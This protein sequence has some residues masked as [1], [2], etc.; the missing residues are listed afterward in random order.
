MYINGNG[1][2]VDKVVGTKWLMLSIERGPSQ[3]DD[4]QH[5]DARK[6]YLREVTSTMNAS[7]VQRAQS[8]ADAW[9]K[10]H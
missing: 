8:L 4:A 2:P 9:L 10:I 6:A 7:E 3:G 1:V 5:V